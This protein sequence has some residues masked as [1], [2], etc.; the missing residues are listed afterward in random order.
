MLSQKL[1][2]VLR[3]L[4]TLVEDALRADAGNKAA[5][6]RVRVAL[7]EARK[8]LQEARKISFH[9]GTAEPVVEV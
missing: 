4:N 7:Q 2:E 5:A 3:I 6:R 9:S 8:G 1:V